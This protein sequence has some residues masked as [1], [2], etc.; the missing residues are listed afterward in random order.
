MCEV[1]VWRGAVGHWSLSS[2]M[3]AS[4]H[5][6]TIHHYVILPLISAQIHTYSQVISH[7]FVTGSQYSR[8]T[9]KTCQMVQWILQLDNPLSPKFVHVWSPQNK[10]TDQVISSVCISDNFYAITYQTKIY[11]IKYNLS[12][13]QL[14]IIDLLNPNPN[15]T[16][17]NT[18][19]LRNVYVWP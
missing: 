3:A 1:V 18:Q 17:T 10:R 16:N 4:P 6:F 8:I 13:K 2:L 12:K 19:H 5:C 14:T 9:I 7:P 15:P 11:F